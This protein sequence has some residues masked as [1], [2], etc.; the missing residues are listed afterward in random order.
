MDSTLG[1][2]PRWACARGF[3]GRCLRPLGYVESEIGASWTTRTSNRRLRRPVLYSI[4]LTRQRTAISAVST[5]DASGLRKPEVRRCTRQAAARAHMHT[6]PAGACAWAH[7]R[8]GRAVGD[9]GACLVFERIASLR[10]ALRSIAGC[11]RAGA[12]RTQRRRGSPVAG[13]LKRVGQKQRPGSLRRPGLLRAW[14]AT[15][16]SRVLHPMWWRHHSHD[17]SHGRSCGN[18]RSRR[19]SPS[20]GRPCPAPAAQHRASPWGCVR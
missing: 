11:E 16:A 20:A 7:P 13:G 18:R 9:A 3:A 6:E 4:E 10:P 12:A 14:K 8:W 2:E 15:A 5:R 19:A 17:R 1:F